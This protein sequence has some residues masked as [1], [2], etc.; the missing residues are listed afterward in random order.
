MFCG[1]AI[2][3]LGHLIFL[4]F[5]TTFT[6]NLNVFVRVKSEVTRAKLS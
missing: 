2:G 6:M 3:V 4:A 5:E 1:G